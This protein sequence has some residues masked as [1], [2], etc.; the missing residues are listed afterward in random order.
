MNTGCC[1]AMLNHYI[2]HLKVI[3]HLMFTMWNM[4]KISNDVFTVSANGLIGIQPMKKHLLQKIYYQ[5]EYLEYL[6]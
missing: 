6:N 2:L 1:I 5:K 4:N 3:L